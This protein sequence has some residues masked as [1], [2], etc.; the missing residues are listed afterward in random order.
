MNAFP[1]NNKHYALWVKNVSESC[2]GNDEKLDACEK[3]LSL[4]GS[5]IY[6][7]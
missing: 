5:N 4:R 7:I 3:F 2:W 6:Y 1:Q